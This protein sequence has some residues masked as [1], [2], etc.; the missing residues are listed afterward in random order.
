[1]SF[2]YTSGP[3]VAA[4]ASPRRERLGLRPFVAVDAADKAGAGLGVFSEVLEH[5]LEFLCPPD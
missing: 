3:R 5:R 1:M 2:R 4:F